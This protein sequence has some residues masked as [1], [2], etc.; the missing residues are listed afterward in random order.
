M[1]IDPARMAAPI[2]KLVDYFADPRYLRLPDG[3]PVFVIG[4][5]RNIRD[6][7]GGK[8]GTTQCFVAATDRFIAELKRASI[9]KI[10][11]APFVQM[12]PGPGWDTMKE[13]DGATCLLPP[14]EVGGGTPYPRLADSV[15]APWVRPG[16]PLSPCMM[17]NFDERPRQ[18]V[19]IAERSAVRYFVGKTDA[20]FR[21]NLLVA[22]RFSD[23]SFAQGQGPASRII[24]LYA[25]NEWHEGGILE[26]NATTGAHDLNIVSEV[27]QLPRAPSRCLD[28][29]VCEAGR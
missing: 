26:P 2:R 13:A 29:G 8:C 20:L 11:V 16:K 24:Y 25:W 4:D 9:A 21:N 6:A 5:V 19:Q 18:D 17:E 10:G 1:A 7:G 3:R 14:V 15:F 28:Q 12:Q 22:K 27:F 23:A